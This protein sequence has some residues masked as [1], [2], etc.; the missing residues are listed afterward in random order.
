MG[1][2]GCQEPG[3]DQGLQ[4]A[5]VSSADIWAQPTKP[6]AAAYWVTKQPGETYTAWRV[7]QECEALE[8]RAKWHDGQAATLRTRATWLSTGG[9]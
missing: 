8:R 7:R 1:P 3:R 4:V 2:G 6:I 9:Q 5:V